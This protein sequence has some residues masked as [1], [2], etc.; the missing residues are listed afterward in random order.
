MLSKY[1]PVPCVCVYMS[2]V[3][4]DA[5]KEAVTPTVDGTSRHGT[6][7]LAKTAVNPQ[8]SQT[9][10]VDDES[11]RG[12]FNQQIS[13]TVDDNSSHD[14]ANPQ[15]STTADDDSRHD[16]ANPQDS[17]NPQNSPTADDDSSHCTVN[18]KNS[19]TAVNEGNLDHSGT[20]AGLN[21]DG[22]CVV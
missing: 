13:K 17:L 8:N 21:T 5:V 19:Q 22:H 16:T 7:S 10:P 18:A 1:L 20:R 12:T 6:M 3:V 4:C 14:T 2:V 11:S 9:Q 15:N